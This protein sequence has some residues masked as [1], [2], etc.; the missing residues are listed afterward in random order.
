MTDAV[1]PSEVERPYARSLRDFELRLMRLAVSDPTWLSSQEDAV[2][3]WALSLARITVVHVRGDG[4]TNPQNFTADVEIG[5]A[6]DAYR[7]KLYQ[8]LLPALGSERISRDGVRAQIPLIR[9]LVADERDSLLRLFGSRLSAKDLDRAV[10]RRPLAL[11]LG[12]GGGVGYV[13]VGAMAALDDAGLTPSL[14]TGTSM[15]AILGAFRSRQQQFSLLQ[16]RSLLAR[17]SWRRVFRLF[18]SQGRFGMPATL[19]LYLRDVLGHAFERGDG[20]FLRMRDLAIPFRVCITGI[21]SRDEALDINRYAHMFD[22]AAQDIKKLRGG[23]VDLMRSLTEL[24]RYPL[25]PIY[26]GGDDLTREFDVLDAIGFSASVPGVIHYDILRDDPRMVDLVTKMLR[27]EGVQR[28]I[29]GGLS[30]NLPAAEALRA[31]QQ[32]TIG[33]RDPLVVA[34]DAFV[35]RLNRHFMFVPIM[36]IAQENSK[37]GRHAAH[38][39][40]EFENV[41]S[42]MTVVPTPREFL[43]AVELG[44][45]EM[46]KHI[47]LIRKLA[48]P[49]PDPHG[50]MRS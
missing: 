16:V 40:I 42:P 38:L 41:L 4:Q 48:G 19:K 32:G 37:V 33:E 5:H 46:V 8:L 47:P 43:H 49:I 18:E 36:S 6:T 45:D 2:L 39:T 24:A 20:T 22:D 28:L 50:V 26:I 34:L 23:V 11:A 31:V 25:K 10:R 21:G 3:R 30:D 9:A 13:F 29:D 35:P 1:S 7:L 14:I 44:R 12:G 17:L 15:G 27:R